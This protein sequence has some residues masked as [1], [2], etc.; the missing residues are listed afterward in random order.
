V[1]EDL[2]KMQVILWKYFS[3][4]TVCWQW[5]MYNPVLIEN[6]S[7]CSF[8]SLEHPASCNP[9]QFVPVSCGR[10]P[11][12]GEGNSTPETKLGVP[13][14]LSDRMASRKRRRTGRRRR[15]PAVDHLGVMIP[16]TRQHGA[17]ARRR[18]RRHRRRRRR[19]LR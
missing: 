2:Y 4:Q 15:R 1:D 5:Y 18:R 14:L 9:S 13:L 17:G 11:S 7:V 6:F 19:V 12:L 8:Y 10:Y 16:Q 3:V